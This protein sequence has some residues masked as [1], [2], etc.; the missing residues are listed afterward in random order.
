MKSR[1][2]TVFG[3]RALT[4]VRNRAPKQIYNVVA[5]YVRSRLGKNIKRATEEELKTLADEVSKMNFGT[6]YKSLSPG[7]FEKK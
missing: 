2:G 3:D 1:L 7:V 5:A 4:I 6:W